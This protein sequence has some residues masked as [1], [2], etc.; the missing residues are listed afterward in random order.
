MKEHLDQLETSRE[1]GS[2]TCQP[3]LRRK[4]MRSKN[5]GYLFYQCRMMGLLGAINI[6]ILVV[7]NHLQCSWA[8]SPKESSKREKDRELSI[9]LCSQVIAAVVSHWLL[10]SIYRSVTTSF[11]FLSQ[12]SERDS[13]KVVK[14]TQD[15]FKRSL[16]TYKFFHKYR[17][18]YIQLNPFF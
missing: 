3:G 15:R 1:R 4:R 8:N 14:P 12:G 11:L 2:S 6:H 5:K 10:L 9:A 18:L 16:P 7:C 17:I 13:I